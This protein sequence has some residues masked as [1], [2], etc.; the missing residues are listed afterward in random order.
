VEELKVVLELLEVTE[1]IVGEPKVE[2]ELLE[3]VETMQLDAVKYEVEQS[4]GD[5]LFPI[6]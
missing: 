3:L 2:L 6:G 1:T 5:C 4:I